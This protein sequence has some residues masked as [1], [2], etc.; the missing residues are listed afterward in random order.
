LFKE[1]FQTSLIAEIIISSSHPFSDGRSL[2]DIGLTIGILNKF[3]RF[4]LPIQFF[5][6]HEYIFHKVVKDHIEE[7]KKEDE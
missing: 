6:L 7:E 1:F 3:F 5:S 2:W 4:N